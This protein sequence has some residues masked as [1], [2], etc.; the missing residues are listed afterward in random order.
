[1]RGTEARGFY[2]GVCTNPTPARKPL[3]FSSR[4]LRVSSRKLRFAAVL[5]P[6]QVL[7]ITETRVASRSRPLSGPKL[8]RFN[9]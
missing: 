6:V 8:A 4:A 9:E 5:D 7:R 1:L 3:L 2:R